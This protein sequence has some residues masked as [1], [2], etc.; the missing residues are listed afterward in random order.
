V[1]QEELQQP[2]PIPSFIQC[3]AKGHCV[4]NSERSFI[5][6]LNYHTKTILS[7][8]GR[9]RQRD[10]I[11]RSQNVCDRIKIGVREPLVAHQRCLCI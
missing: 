6:S 5:N 1:N 3:Q 9:R 7:T 11:T 4:Q 2:T 10:N 8:D